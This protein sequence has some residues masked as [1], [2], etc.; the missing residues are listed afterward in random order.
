M[1]QQIAV[2]DLHSMVGKEVLGFY[3]VSEKELREGKAGMYLR[4]KLQDKTGSVSA[5][6]WTNA[7]M[8]AQN[9]E[10]GDVIKLKAM[11]TSYKGQIQLS[12]SRTRLADDSEYQIETFLNRS[13]KDPDAMAEIFWGF[14]D[15]VQ[16]PHLKAMLHVIFDDKE[17]FARFM[18]APAAKSWH[19]NYVHGLLEHINAVATLCDYLASRYPVDRDILI[20]G[21]LLHDVAKVM[22]YSTMP[23]IDFT[24]EGR[25]IG[26]LSL[27]DQLLCNAAAKVNAF[28]S[29]TLMHLRH[30]ILAHHGEYEK[31]SVRLPQTLEALVLHLADNMDAQITG[32]IQLVQSAAPDALWTEFD[33]LNNRYYRIFKPQD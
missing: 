31:A 8:E 21:A 3:L 26:H 12:V 23:K 2:K 32:V 20:C 27:S 22:E 17:F 10:E 1:E 15:S 24:D 33:K 16:N 14:I 29:E 7:E 13:S 30:L 25:L 6:V 9:F 18:Q 4:L 11:V 19:H 28:P 5:N